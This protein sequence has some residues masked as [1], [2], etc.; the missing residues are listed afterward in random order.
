MPRRLPDKSRYEEKR[1]RGYG[2]YGRP[3]QLEQMVRPSPVKEGEEYEAVIEDV[4]SRGDGICN[5]KGF[6]TYVR[7]AKTGERVKIRITGV[8]GGFATAVVAEKTG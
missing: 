4:G 8:M 7:G 3:V 2:S 6:R 5:I 1:A